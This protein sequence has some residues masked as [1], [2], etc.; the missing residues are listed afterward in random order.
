MEYYS[1]LKR[2]GCEVTPWRDL[3]CILL[4]ERSQSAKAPFCP[5]PA[6]W[7]RQNYG[8]IKGSELAKG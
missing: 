8:E 6:F 4:E 2:D 5:I 1:M 7:K 3:K